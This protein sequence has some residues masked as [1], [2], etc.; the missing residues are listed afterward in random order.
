MSLDCQHLREQCHVILA[1]LDDIDRYGCEG[2]TYVD[3]NHSLKER[4]MHTVDALEQSLDQDSAPPL[5]T[6]STRW[7]QVPDAG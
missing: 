5:P 1:L 2:Y 6:P 3:T 7:R 4:L